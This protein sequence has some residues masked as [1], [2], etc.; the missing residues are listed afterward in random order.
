MVSSVLYNNWEIIRNKIYI[1]RNKVLKPALKSSDF[2]AGWDQNRLLGL[3]NANISKQRND[4][5]PSIVNHYL[6][7]IPRPDIVFNKG[8]WENLEVPKLDQINL[9]DCKCH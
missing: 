1:D 4:T 9:D 3:A 6:L 7:I 5:V 2:V 8:I